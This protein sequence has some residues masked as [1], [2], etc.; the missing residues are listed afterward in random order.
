MRPYRYSLICLAL[1]I[2]IDSLWA[3]TDIVDGIKTQTDILLESINE[4]DTLTMTNCFWES[5]ETFMIVQ[6]NAVYGYDS[7]T[8][9]LIQSIKSFKS[10]SV[11]IIEDDVIPLSDSSGVHVI[12][13][14]QKMTSLDKD[15]TSSSGSMNTYY[16]TVD[17]AWKII[18][19]HESFS[20]ADN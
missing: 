16:H 6:G 10:I 3:Q 14:E 8:H 20:P 13:F 9:V 4:G 15:K 1:F 11:E 12:Q 19:I 2:T 7:I 18:G 5:E 17:G